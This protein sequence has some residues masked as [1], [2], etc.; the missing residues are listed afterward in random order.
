MLGSVPTMQQT[1]ITVTDYTRTMIK[2]DEEHDTHRIKYI[3]EVKRQDFAGYRRFWKAYTILSGK[4]CGVTS[5][6]GNRHTF[7]K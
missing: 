2:R 3:P 4:G 5:Q 7:A 6:D 1:K